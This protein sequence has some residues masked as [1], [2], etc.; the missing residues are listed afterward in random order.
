MIHYFVCEAERVCGAPV[1]GYVMTQLRRAVL[2]VFGPAGFMSGLKMITCWA[3]ARSIDRSCLPCFVL[4]DISQIWFV[5]PCLG[6][7]AAGH[8][9][10][11]CSAVFSVAATRWPICHV[12]CLLL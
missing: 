7:A 10:F 2:V 5:F 6:E 1:L 3:S 9:L 8:G 4:Q 11:G 12:L